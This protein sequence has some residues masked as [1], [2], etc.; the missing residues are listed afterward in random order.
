[1]YHGWD[2]TPI[3]DSIWYLVADSICIAIF[4]YCDSTSIA[5]QHYN[6]LQFLLTFLT[7]DHG[8]KLNHTLLGTFTLGAK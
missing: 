1:M 6:L 7:L 3:S 8:K 2:D 4:K 5:I